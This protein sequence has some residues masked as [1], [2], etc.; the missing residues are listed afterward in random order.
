MVLYISSPVSCSYVFTTVS[1]T[2][3]Y[4][5]PAGLCSEKFLAFL[6]SASNVHSFIQCSISLLSAKY[7]LNS[8]PLGSNLFPII[9]FCPSVVLSYITVSSPLPLLNLNWVTE[10]FLSLN[11]VW[12]PPLGS[13]ICFPVCFFLCNWPTAVPSQ[14]LCVLSVSPWS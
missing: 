8:H 14:W 13:I 12:W 2:S 11:Y 5:A 3:L 7:L 6:C 1:M 9:T 4:H 10:A